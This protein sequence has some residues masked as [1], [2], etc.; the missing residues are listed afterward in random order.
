MGLGCLLSLCVAARGRAEGEEEVVRPAPQ[1]VEGAIRAEAVEGAVSAGSVESARVLIPPYMRD[2]TN[3][4]T[5]TA[6]FPLYFGRHGRGSR[7]L[8]VPPY[9]YRR[10]PKLNVDVALGLAW[11]LRGPERNTFVLPPLYTHRDRKDWGVGLFPLFSTGV[12]SGHHHTV[13]PALL[14]W[15]DGDADKHHML[16]GPAFHFRDHDERFWG[17][18]PIL[19][20]KRDSN[21]AAT[22]IPPIFWRFREDD[23]LNITTV[24]GIFYHLRRQKDTRWGLPPL[25]FG[26]STPE[27]RSLTV[28]F[29]LFHHAKGP[30]E[31]RLI[32]PLMSYLDS[33]EGKRWWTPIYQ[34]KRGERGYDAV[35]PFYVRTWDTR[36]MSHGLY[37]PPFYW[38]KSD[39]A[40]DVQLILPFLLRVNHVGISKGWLTPLIGHFQ[41]FEKKEQTWWAFPTFHY[42]EDASSWQ[43]NIH[44]LVYRKRA[45]DHSHLVLAPLWFDFRNSTKKTHRTAL[46][47]LWWNFRNYEKQ[48]AGRALPPIYWDFEDK[49]A[50]TRR[51]VGFPLYWDF[52]N[53]RAQARTQVVFPFYLRLQRGGAL[54]HAVLNTYYERKNEPSHKSWQFHFFPLLSFGGGQR[55][56]EDDVWWNLLYGVAGYERRGPHRRIQALFLPIQLKD[57]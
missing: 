24:A 43:F 36:D 31:F 12:Y 28:P 19:W 27:L 46:F 20:G 2:V 38:R 7:E 16:F 39:P 35:A 34:G 15:V 10:S 57:R 44:P 45:T 25:V 13:I 52:R 55:G 1:R 41:N 49:K 11:S 30:K 40:N 8:F 3:G 23:P 6:L 29:L 33:D 47:P 56:K 51:I 54:G 4:V 17:L 18:F 50:Q 42:G 9:Y 53:D 5:T 32:T 48:T 21:S 26:A 14:T 22:V 37:V